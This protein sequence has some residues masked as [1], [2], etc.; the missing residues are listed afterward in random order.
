MRRRR[1]DTSFSGIGGSMM[2][3]A[4]VS[5]IFPNSDL[6]VVGLVEIVS[7]AA[8]IVR[9][10]KKTVRW[11]ADNR[12]SLLI[13]IDYPEFNMLL[14]ARAV[15]LGI[16]VMY[17]ISPQIWAWRQGRVHKLKK[18]VDRMVVI[19]PF[20]EEFYSRFGM[21]VDFVG[22]P[23]VDT[24]RAETDRDAFCSALG[25]DTG[26]PLVSLLPGSRGGEIERLL[27]LLRDAADIVHKAE[28]DVQFVLPV[29]PGLGPE[30]LSMLEGAVADLQ[31]SGVCV[32]IV[33][34]MTWDAINASD[35]AVAASGTVTLEAAILGTP[36]VVVYRLAPLS[37][38]IGRLLVRVRYASLV[39]LVADREI[40]PELIQ[41]DATP[42]R[43]ARVVREL[44]ADRERYGKLVRDMSGAVGKL[45]P[46]GALDRAAE[47]ACG[48]LKAG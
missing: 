15:K 12:P 27:P 39:N 22:H 29:A 2:K 36:S 3:E 41:N 31:S 43:L 14:A 1:P 24:V 7:H 16:P 48:F 10:F 30:S 46:P 17:F 4:G 35:M 34:G 37:Y 25:L 8:S 5:L 21:K 23:L 40:L 6:A 20:E 45:G 18:L 42:V 9:A 13:L 44:L 28:P 47:I 19:L 33:A 32:Q 26:R 11:L 38:H